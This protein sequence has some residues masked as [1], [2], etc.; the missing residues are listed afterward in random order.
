M[1]LNTISPD[2]EGPFEDMYSCISVVARGYL[3]KN[4]YKIFRAV[5]IRGI[6]SRVGNVN[7]LKIG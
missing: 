3:G 1:I 5:P 6:L 7:W 4:L 2:E